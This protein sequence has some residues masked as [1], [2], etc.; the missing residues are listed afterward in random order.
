MNIFDRIDIWLTENKVSRR[1]LAIDAGLPPSSLQSVLTRRGTLPHTMLD[2]LSRTMGV[3][4]DYLLRGDRVNDITGA[5][6]NAEERL[7]KKSG[8]YLVAVATRD[9]RAFCYITNSEYSARH[10]KFNACDWQTDE[11]VK[12]N[13]FETRRLY[14]MPMPKPPKEVIT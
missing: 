9:G 10:K 1:R 6:I 8:A 5:W 12:R 11:E 7:P 4:A 2:A 3:T 14:W 13:A